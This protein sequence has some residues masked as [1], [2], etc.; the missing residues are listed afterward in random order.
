MRIRL[1][2]IFFLV[3]FVL[4]SNAGTLSDKVVP[5]VSPDLVVNIA[6]IGRLISGNQDPVTGIRDHGG[7]EPNQV[8]YCSIPCTVVVTNTGRWAARPIV[9]DLQY[10]NSGFSSRYAFFFSVPGSRLSGCAYF[11][12]ALAPGSSKTISGKILSYPRVLPEYREMER[13][14]TRFRFRVDPPDSGNPNGRVRELREDNNYSSW[15]GTVNFPN[16]LPD[17]SVRIDSITP[18]QPMERAPDLE[19][20]RELYCSIVNNGDID[21]F[22]RGCGFKAEVYSSRSGR[23]R[24]AGT[25]MIGPSSIPNG[26]GSVPLHF[27]DLEVYPDENR[28]RI[29]VDPDNR[30]AEKN[31]GN[32]VAERDI[33]RIR[34]AVPP[35]KTAP[36]PVR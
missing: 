35:V 12:E 21:W 36:V 31:E 6:S 19:F 14:S 4:E 24:V 25:G 2:I 23:W 34:I 10:E 11:D 20:I 16:V 8:V 26:G 30:V 18:A 5:A 28:I 3:F 13:G 27:A 17:L 22:N 7:S 29:T 32:N 1:P 9:V 33:P 15:S